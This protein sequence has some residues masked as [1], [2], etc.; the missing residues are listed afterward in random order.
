MSTMTFSPL[1]ATKSAMLAATRVRNCGLSAG[2]TNRHRRPRISPS[3]IAAPRCSWVLCS[4]TLE[5]AL[6]AELC[7]GF[8]FASSCGSQSLASRRQELRIATAVYRGDHR[9]STPPVHIHATAE[10]QHH[11]LSAA[12]RRPRPKHTLRL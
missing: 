8:C 12:V 2:I 7:L 11:F 10:S 4:S 9:T 6:G 3:D 1:E 5:A